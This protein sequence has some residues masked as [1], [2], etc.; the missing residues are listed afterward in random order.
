MSEEAVSA[1]IIPNLAVG[2]LSPKTKGTKTYA[3]RVY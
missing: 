1:D 3:A 2:I